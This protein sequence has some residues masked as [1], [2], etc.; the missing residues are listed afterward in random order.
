[1]AKLFGIDP[2]ADEVIVATGT[3]PPAGAAAPSAAKE[4]N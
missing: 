4:P 1:M 3:L 2:S